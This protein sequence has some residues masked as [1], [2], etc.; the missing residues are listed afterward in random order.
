MFIFQII[1]L[2]KNISISEKYIQAGIYLNL[3]KKDAKKLYEEIIL[4]SK[5]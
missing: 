3:N 4:M 2:I 5:K 1:V